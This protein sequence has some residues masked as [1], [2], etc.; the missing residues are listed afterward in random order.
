MR[1][2][3]LEIGS[4]SQSSRQFLISE[5]PW[6]RNQGIAQL[7]NGPSIDCVTDISSSRVHRWISNRAQLQPD[8]TALLSAESQKKITYRELEL[9]SNQRVHCKFPEFRTIY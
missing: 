8:S 6:F 1:E 4:L 5:L 2:Q 9:M 7:I 3:F